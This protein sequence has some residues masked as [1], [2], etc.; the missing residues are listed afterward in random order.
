[1]DENNEFNI[2]LEIY[3]ESIDQPLFY[4]V[5]MTNA[6]SIFFSHN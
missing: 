5:D 4:K 1:M 6:Q 2:T 3:L